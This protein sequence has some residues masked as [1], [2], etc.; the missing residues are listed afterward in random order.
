MSQHIH[1]QHHHYDEQEEKKFMLT[2]FTFMN[3]R[4]TPIEKIPIFDHKELNLYRLYSCVI[5]RGGLESVI[6]NKLWRQ[7]TTDLEVDPERT[8]AG[9]RLRIHYLKYLYPFERLNFLKMDDDTNFDFEAYEK[10]LSKTHSEKK[11]ANLK[12]KKMA[13]AAAHSHPHMSM[14]SPPNSAKSTPSP[15]SSPSSLLMS[16]TMSM[17]PSSDCHATP[18]QFASPHA[19]STSA[20]HNTI[21]SLLNINNLYN[22]DQHVPPSYLAHTV[23]PSPYDHNEEHFYPLPSSSSI[24]STSSTSPY[25]NNQSVNLR[26][27]ELKSL[28][29]YNAVH[30]LKVSNQPSRRELVKAVIHHFDQQQNIDEESIII[31]FLRRIKAETNNTSIIRPLEKT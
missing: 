5:S 12:K 4:G 9:F 23:E 14:V 15:T 26:Q 22:V 20:A 28:R 30:R 19:H 24:S 2:L 17:H 29:K 8:D 3:N 7:I 13:S 18:P 16:S 25:N 31:Q 21:E 27:L 6:E 10:H 1:Q 11:A